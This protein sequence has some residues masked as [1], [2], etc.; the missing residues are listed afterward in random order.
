[1][2][3]PIDD[4]FNDVFGY[5]PKKDGTAFEMLSAI[6]MDFI[7][8]D[9]EIAHDQKIRGQFSETLYQIDSLAKY[10]N[11]IT[12]G[13][14]KDYSERDGKVGRPDLQKLGGAFPDLEETTK[15]T[16]FSATGYTKPAQ[17]YAKQAQNIVGKPIDL[18]R[19]EPT[20]ERDKDGTIQKIVITGHIMVPLMNE[21]TFTPVITD[22]GEKK[23]REDLEE[24]E[25]KEY[26][27]EI[28]D[29]YDKDG[30]V[31]DSLYHITS[32]QGQQG[33]NKDTQIA[34]SKY[35]LKGSYIKIND[36]LIEIE[37]LEYEIP[38]REIVKVMEITNN[39]EARLTLKTLDGDVISIL[40]DAKL[41]KYS[42][43]ND[44]NLKKN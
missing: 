20:I 11:D 2:S 31:I 14:A 27:T 33:F 38:Y 22:D 13:E 35:D 21:G 44:G 43:D 9:S 40:S 24:N 34:K 10:E 8:D 6:A 26:S 18:Y 17:K 36:K 42:F 12:V 16:F 30:N 29:F 39:S 4:I 41:K 1:M 23:L 37:A 7:F 25:S 19:L 32:T 28:S 15:G 3:S 5:T